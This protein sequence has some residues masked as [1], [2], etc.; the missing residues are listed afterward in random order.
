[1]LD[2]QQKLVKCLELGISDDTLFLD[3]ND[4][5]SWYSSFG[6]GGSNNIDSE[7]SSTLLN[8]YSQADACARFEEFLDRL[9]ISEQGLDRFFMSSGSEANSKKRYRQLIRVFHPDRGA[10]E[11]VWLNYRAEKINRAYQRYKDGDKNINS[12]LSQSESVVTPHRSTEATINRKPKAKSKPQNF[13]LKYRR[14]ELRNLLGDPKD[15]Q[16]RLLWILGC[17]SLLLILIFYASSRTTEKNK[18]LDATLIS[19]YDNDSEAKAELPNLESLSIS[20]SSDSGLS[21][22][23]DEIQ[24]DFEKIEK[25]TD[26]FDTLNAEQAQDARSSINIEEHDHFQGA[27]DVDSSA[28]S[29][30]ESIVGQRTESKRIVQPPKPV[31]QEATSQ[32][33]TNVLLAPKRKPEMKRQTQLTRQPKVTSEPKV[34]RQFEIGRQTEKKVSATSPICSPNTQVVAV[35]SGQKGY[36]SDKDVRLRVGPSVQCRIMHVLAQKTPVT[37]LKR[38][39]DGLWCYVDVGDRSAPLRGWV[40]K[41]FFTAASVRSNQPHSSQKTTAKQKIDLFLERYIKGFESGDLNALMA[42]YMTEAVEDDMKGSR[43][44]ARY[45]QGAFPRTLKRKLRFSI[46]RFEQDEGLTAVISGTY[47]IVFNSSENGKLSQ[48]NDRFEMLLFNTGKGYKIA[49]LQWSK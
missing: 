3:L 2:W 37:L 33:K 30:I 25:I 13:K 26:A 40:S 7:L 24:N 27:V 28:G 19:Q 20:V 41:R 35:G 46:N 8:K 5:L 21:N 10:K 38:S 48:V 44:I 17:L 1:M 47:S 39:P 32:S 12:T 16:R 14:N 9:L 34:T 49:S 4:I 42:L 36:I 29:I 43:K 31:V 22:A 23:V 11:Q 6:A 15:V 18:P 45:Y